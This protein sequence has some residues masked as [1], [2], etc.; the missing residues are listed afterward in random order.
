MHSMTIH[1]I[2]TATCHMVFAQYQQC[3]NFFF[4][5]DKITSGKY[6]K[7]ES[8]I[9]HFLVYKKKNNKTKCNGWMLC[10]TAYQPL[11]VI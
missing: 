2:G 1:K 9:H 5:A 4:F 3:R 10:F 7:T 11:S 6:S 8:R